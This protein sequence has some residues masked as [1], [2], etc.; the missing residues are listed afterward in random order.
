MVK[1]WNDYEDTHLLKGR[2][3]VF[4]DYTQANVQAKLFTL[5]P[6]ISQLKVYGTDCLGEENA[7]FATCHDIDL[8]NCEFTKEKFEAFLVSLESTTYLTR[9]RLWGCEFEK[10]ANIN[11]ILLAN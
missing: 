10:K 4:V 9:L 8:E 6:M 3:N 7:N 2:L 5:G 11:Q 1:R